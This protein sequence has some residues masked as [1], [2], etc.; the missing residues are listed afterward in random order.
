MSTGI[1]QFLQRF[2]LQMS[3]MGL[4]LIGPL[5]NISTGQEGLLSLTAL[6]LVIM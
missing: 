1:Q 2:I 5:T 3:D 4:L 6:A